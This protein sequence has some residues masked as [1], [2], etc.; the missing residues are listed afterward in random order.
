VLCLC[1]LLPQAI[2][3]GLLAWKYSQDQRSAMEHAAMELAIDRR[4]DL[5]RELSGM[6]ATLQAIATSP[7]MAQGDFQGLDRQAREVVRLR[8]SLLIM[9]D[10]NGQ[11]I[12]N[13]NLPYGVPLPRST[14]PALLE[15]DAAI[16]ETRQPG[17][18]DLYRGTVTGMPRVMVGVPVIIDG[19]ARY[20]IDI[21]IEPEKLSTYLHDLPD[22]WI[23]SIVDRSHR[24][25][26]RSVD[27]ER[28][29]GQL[30]TAEF[31]A[32]LINDEGTFH[33]GRTL[34][35]VSVFTAYQKSKLSGWT[36]SFAIPDS[37]LDL[38]MQ[39]LRRALLL[40]GGVAVF[41]SILFASLY[42]RLIGR[43]LRKLASAASHVGLDDFKSLGPSRVAEIDGLGHVLEQ[44]DADLKRKD[45]HHKTLLN[46]LDHRVKNTL[47]ILQS[48][49]TLSLR[50][51]E[52][53]EHFRIAI[54]GR[55][56]ALARAHEVL[57]TANWDRPEL[58]DVAHMILGRGPSRISYAGTRV[59]L[60]A[61]AVV[62]LAQCFQELLS[63]AQHHGALHE[64]EGS[65]ALRWLL[66]EERRTIL[67]SW[68][69]TMPLLE[70]PPNGFREG[71]GMQIV[72][73]CIERQLGGTCQ[74]E[75]TDTGL[76]F[77]ATIP[78]Q[79][80]LGKNG[81]LFIEA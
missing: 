51:A 71:F 14:D 35:G 2:M 7:A 29:V 30:G 64:P 69:E 77:T 3:G 62:A 26:T 21:G 31:R 79:S 80:E 58:V 74:F 63:N 33:R 10:R 45:R 1:V 36:V 5:D 24:V 38:P 28:Y 66:N 12:I 49:V 54:S 76:N 55:V 17:V 47:A 16:L 25:I 73:I 39:A 11:Q 48:L 8:G 56:N 44:A 41:T 19:E 72:R 4:G 22:G 57:S 32:N 43:S 9:R 40:M 13:T 65:V 52:S 20:V 59:R 18:S 42:G 70:K 15:T 27:L 34:E 75:F 53:P 68:I 67:L 50:T 23:A 60:S 78:L 37:Y 61:S 46:E 81:E 6:I